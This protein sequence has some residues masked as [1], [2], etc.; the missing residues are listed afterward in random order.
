MIPIC[1]HC[2]EE[3]GANYSVEHKDY[4]QPED[5]DFNA[6]AY[7]GEISLFCDGGKALRKITDSDKKFLEENPEVFNNIQSLS[8]RI[9]NDLAIRS[10]KVFNNSYRSNL[11]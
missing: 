2:D 10:L 4:L 7:C 1:P 9:K 6:C 11:N 3:L 8:A 5:D